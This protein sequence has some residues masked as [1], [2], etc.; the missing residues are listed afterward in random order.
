[1]ES[2]E[3]WQAL[4][5]AAVHSDPHVRPS[6]RPNWRQEAAITCSN[7]GEPTA[8]FDPCETVFVFDIFNDPC[9]LNNLASSQPELRERLLRK[10]AT[11]RSIFS[12]RPSNEEVDENGQP[13]HHNCTWAPWVNVEASPYRTCSC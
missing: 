5:E 6:P 7:S 8:S 9:E 1:M 11:Y 3:A 13:Q 4:Q 2:S 10:L 12:P